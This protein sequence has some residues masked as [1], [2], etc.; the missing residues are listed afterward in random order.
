MKPHLRL[1]KL[2]IVEDAKQIGTRSIIRLRI[3]K[4]LSFIGR[5]PETMGLQFRKMVQKDGIFLES[6]LQN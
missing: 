3:T 5:C 2:E 4:T 6:I 1:D